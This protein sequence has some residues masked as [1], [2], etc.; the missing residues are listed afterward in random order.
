MVAGNLAEKMD[1]HSFYLIGARAGKRPI[2][3]YD[4]ISL[5][6]TGAEL[7]HPK[8]GVRDCLEQNRSATRE[9]HC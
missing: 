2:A 7:S 3:S 9:R 6:K 1:A 8:F 5:N 4:Q